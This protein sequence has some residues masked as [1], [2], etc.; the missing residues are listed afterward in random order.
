MRVVCKRLL[1]EF[2]A[3]T[4]C[5]FCG[6][7]CPDGCDPAHLYS[8]GAGRV[9]IRENLCSLCR[10]CHTRSHAGGEPNREQLLAIA[11]KREGTTPDEITEKVYRFRRDDRVKI[12]VVD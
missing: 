11:A 4:T 10:E 1:R 8:R 5:E 12:W 2:A 9:D 7:H 3:K 6:I